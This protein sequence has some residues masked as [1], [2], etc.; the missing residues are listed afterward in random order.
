VGPG[1]G[2]SLVRAF[3]Q[4]GY[5]VAALARGEDRL[6]SIVDEIDGARAFPCDA[7][8]AEEVEATFASIEEQLGDVEALMYNA[9][10]GVWGQLEEVDADDLRTCWEVNT[11]GLFLAARQVAPG[12]RERGSGVIGVTGATASTR[13][14]PFTTA[15]AQ[16]KMAQRGLA[17]SMARELGPDGVHV[18]YAVVD[19][20]IDTP[21][22]REQMSDKDDDFF[23]DPDDIARS[24]LAL[25]QQPESAWTFEIDLR[26]YRESW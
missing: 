4:E 11:L 23:L 18:F 3:A 16:A 12:M 25:A 9:G 14:K 19:G 15:F 6:R 5:R 1:T 17:Q 8:S 21:A 26:P 20:V 22:T 13:G 24:Y 7:T 10:T 2:A